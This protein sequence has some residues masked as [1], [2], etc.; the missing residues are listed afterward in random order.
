MKLIE[1]TEDY[2]CEWES[3]ISEFEKNKEKLT[4][5]KV[6]VHQLILL[7]KMVEL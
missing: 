7:L 1:L 5:L 3:L 6:I 4:V 2:K